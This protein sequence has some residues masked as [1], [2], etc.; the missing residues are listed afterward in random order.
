MDINPVN[1]ACE[2]IDRIY[3]IVERPGRLL[4]ADPIPMSYFDGTLIFPSGAATPQQSSMGNWMTD[5][6]P[7]D[8]DYVGG[9]M[10]IIDQM[11][12][13]QS[14]SLGPASPKRMFQHMRRVIPNAYEL[15][16]IWIGDLNEKGMRQ[17]RQMGIRDPMGFLHVYFLVIENGS[18]RC[19]RSSES[20]D[21]ERDTERN[22]L[23]AADGY[24]SPV[25][26]LLMH[27]F[28]N[29]YEWRVNIEC[30]NGFSVSVNAERD[31]IKDALRLRKVPPGKNRR[32]SLLHWVREHYRAKPGSRVRP[33]LRGRDVAEMN[34]KTFKVIPPRYLAAV[35]KR[36]DLVYLDDERITDHELCPDCGALATK[37]CVKHQL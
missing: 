27:Q 37:F 11:G 4:R 13:R 32:A 5:I 7:S 3:D 33:H 22:P 29:R 20:R 21:D 26:G 35:A 2:S 15:R 6:R 23:D 30:D 34:D 1:A 24:I 9:R 8:V 17:A 18:F 28:V 36:N 19:V 31:S 14:F 25:T 12:N 10:T 16:K